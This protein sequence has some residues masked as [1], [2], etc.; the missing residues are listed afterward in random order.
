[1]S[2]EHWEKAYAAGDQGKSWYQDQ[3]DASLDLIGTASPAGS[4]IDVGGGASTLVDGLLAAGF[5]DLTVLDIADAG[6]AIARRRLGERAAAVQWVQ[7]DLLDWRPERA[8]DL[9]HDRAVLHFLVADA[10][11]G[12]YREQLL[13]A[14]AVGSRAVIGCFGPVGPESCSGLPVRRADAADLMAVLGE[15]FAE[16]RAFTAEHLTPSGGIQQFQWLLAER[17]G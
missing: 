8:Y 1:M 15:R 16:R 6:M 17:I 12:R 9:W 14:T 7:A 4:V 13:A 5:T 3:A 10:D 11:R 2:V